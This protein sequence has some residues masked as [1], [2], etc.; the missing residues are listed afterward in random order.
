MKSDIIN[1]VENYYSKKIK[2]HGATSQG[3]DWNGEESHFLR[4]EQ[5]TKYFAIDSKVSILDY[6]SGFGS[7]I[8][9]LKLNK[10]NF[11]YLG[12]DLSSEMVT[13]G[14]ELYRASNIQFTTEENE[15]IKQ[16]YVVANGIFNVKLTTPEE[17][18][19]KYILETIKE[20]DKFSLKGFS[21]N[22]LT[23][24]SDEEFKKDYLHYANPLDIFDYCKRNFSKNVALLHDYDLYEFTIIVRK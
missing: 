20:L 6:G 7:L 15:L 1:K 8:D 9:F 22:I 14:K 11:D 10:Y 4:F 16:D 13:K 2:V 17:E 3:V 21:F 24:Y 12:Y 5:L 19:K 23:S 18:W